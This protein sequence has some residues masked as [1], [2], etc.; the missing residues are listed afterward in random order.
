MN[1]KIIN[2]T[3]SII[4]ILT[5]G[6]TAGYALGYYRAAH[7]IFPEIRFTDSDVNQGVATLKLMEVKNGKL[8][9][10]SAG[11]KIRIAYSADKIFDLDP[12]QSFDIPLNGINLSAYYKTDSVPSYALF[13][14]SKKGKY[15]YSVFDKR[16]YNLGKSNIIY[17]K[18][19]SEAEKMG[20]IK[21]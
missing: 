5:I 8:S 13:A 16:V 21:K 10:E 19:S 4:L 14:A 6:S 12:G 11:K 3:F 7:N 9:V 15:F 20:Y 1:L 2:L 18:T 17:F